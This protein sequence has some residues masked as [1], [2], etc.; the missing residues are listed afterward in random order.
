MNTLLCA[1]AAFAPQSKCSSLIDLH[2]RRLNNAF[3]ED[4]HAGPK[5]KWLELNIQMLLQQVLSMMFVFIPRTDT[6]KL[7][8]EHSVAAPAWPRKKKK[9]RIPYSLS[10]SAPDRLAHERRQGGDRCCGSDH[11]RG[12]SDRGRGNSLRSERN[13]QVGRHAH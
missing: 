8:L 4:E 10:D 6:N 7:S 3:L 5:T 9:K 13:C 2:T 11:V 12:S 1:I